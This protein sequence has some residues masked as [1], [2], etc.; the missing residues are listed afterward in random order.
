LQV[1]LASRTADYRAAVFPPEGLGVQLAG[2]TGVELC[3]L[4]AG[5]VADYLKDSAGGPAAATR[6]DPVISILTVD[7]Q[8]PVATALSTPLM[9]ALARASYNPRPRETLAAIP[10]P[11]ELLDQHRFPSRKAIELYLFDRFIPA[12]YRS[13][14]SPSRPFKYSAQQAERWLVFLA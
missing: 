10:N 14:S 8:S 4:G 2:A 9:A 1:V 5:V 3:P 7:S 13:P 12:V 11:D 6:W